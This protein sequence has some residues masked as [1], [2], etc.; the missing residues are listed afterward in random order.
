MLVGE[1]LAELL[2]VV[3]DGVAVDLDAEVVQDSLDADERV[4]GGDIQAEV[5][6]RPVVGAPIVEQLRTVGRDGFLAVGAPVALIIDGHRLVAVLGDE[7]GIDAVAGVVLLVVQFAALG[8][9]PRRVQG[10]ILE[11]AIAIADGLNEEA[12]RSC[13]DFN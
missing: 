2:G 1:F 11:A 5:D 6:D 3:L 13:V 9:G 7:F 12:L 8:T 4:L 10:A